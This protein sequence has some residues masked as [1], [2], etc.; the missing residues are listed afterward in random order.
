MKNKIKVYRAMHDLTQE[1][2]AQALGVTRQT[3]L[4]IEKGKYDPSLELA[5]RMAR[6]FNTTIEEIF[7][8][9]A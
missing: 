5:F 3:I 6:Y 7:T 8:F 4:A 9:E 1:G 2:L